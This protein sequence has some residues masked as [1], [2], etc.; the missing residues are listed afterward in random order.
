MF[1][2][3]YIDRP[4]I[5]AVTAEEIQKHMKELLAQI[6]MRIFVAGNVFKDVSNVFNI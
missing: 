5:S 6:N 1:T 4:L 2:K 3:L